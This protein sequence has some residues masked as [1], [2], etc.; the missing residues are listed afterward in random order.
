MSGK[1]YLGIFLGF[2]WIKS[3]LQEHKDLFVKFTINVFT[4]ILIIVSII[5]IEVNK[6]DWLFP[7]IGAILVTV[8]GI[9]TPKLIAKYSNQEPPSSA[10][11]CTSSFSNGLNF[12]YPI[13]FALSPDAIGAASIFLAVAIILRNTVGF[14]LSG[15]SVKK[16][17]IKEILRFPPIIAIVVG[18]VFNP[19][20]NVNVSKPNPAW[21]IMEV[22]ITATLMTIGFG[23]KKPDFGLKIPMMRVAVSRYVVSG[24]VALI[25][26]YSFS[27]SSDISLALFVQMIAPP[28][29]Y[30]GLY[31]ERFGL[32]TTLTSQ[33]IITLTMVA[34][35]F[36]PLE[37]YIVQTLFVS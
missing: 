7:V 3:P 26:I 32:D 35:I 6:F 1:I 11:L 31:A 23:L 15:I 9:I 24:I 25:L 27:L 28:A 5:N 37:L 20:L 29:V 17:N 14:Y 8:I 21:L 13:I 34:L 18:I 22:G 12:P 36:L 2:I 16:E 4:P 33:I 30:N 19:L 10:E